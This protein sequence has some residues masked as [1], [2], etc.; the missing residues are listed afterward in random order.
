MPVSEYRRKLKDP[1]AAGLDADQALHLLMAYHHGAVVDLDEGYLADA[2]ALGARIRE[3]GLDV[4]LYQMPVPVEQA[5][6]VLGPE[7]APYIEARTLAL[8]NAFQAGFSPDN[9]ARA[10]IV[11]SGTSL[12]SS[13]F[14]D[15]NDGSE[16]VNQI[17]RHHIADQ[18]IAEVTP[19][20]AQRR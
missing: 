9:T 17:G 4:V 6:K 16:H 20:L 18:V 10:A 7:V 11:H 5:V 19:K 2:T 14:I 13:M 1:A 8:E 12:P 15:P 3:L